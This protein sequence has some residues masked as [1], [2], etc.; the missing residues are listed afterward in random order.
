MKIK[1]AELIG[2]KCE[3]IDDGEK[4]YQLLIVELRNGRSVEL[5]FT[6]VSSVITPFLNASLGKLLDLFEKET[7]MEKLI[8]CHISADHLRRVNEFIDFK[9]K[10]NSEATTRELMQDLFEEDE[11]GDD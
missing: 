8:L 4:L 1:M 3:S 9:H 11:L 7:L 5:D 6:D 10:K 2:E